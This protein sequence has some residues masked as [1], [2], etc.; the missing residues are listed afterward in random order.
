[1]EN[2]EELQQS[3]N[4]EIILRELRSAFSHYVHLCMQK[5]TFEMLNPENPTELCFERELLD[6][7]QDLGDDGL[8]PPEKLENDIFVT[9]QKLFHL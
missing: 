2:L 6:S 5:K 4:S 7:L 1:M 9:S 3:N 8:L